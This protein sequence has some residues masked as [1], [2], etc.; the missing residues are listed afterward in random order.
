[1]RIDLNQPVY[2]GNF[3]LLKGSSNSGKRSVAKSAVIEYSKHP[4]QHAIYITSS[5]QEAQDLRSKVDNSNCTIIT[6]E[7]Q[8]NDSELYMLPKLGLM[9][10]Q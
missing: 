7:N 3:T 10:A 5:P 1:M 4:N 6:P 9:L 8:S 2:E